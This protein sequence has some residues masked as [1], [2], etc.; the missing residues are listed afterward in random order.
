MKYARELI[1]STLVGGVFVV[2]PVYLAVLLLLKVMRSLGG[3]V[4]PV[5]ALVPDRLPAE[6]LLSLAL[7]MTFCLAVGVAIRTSTGRAVRERMEMAFLERL[8]GYGLLRRLTRRL[9]G[10]SDESTW[11]PA[12]AEIHGALVPAFII[13]ELE[14]G[15]F[16]IF[17]PSVPTPLAGAVYVISRERVHLLDIPFTGAIK[18]VSRLGSGAKNIVAAM[19]T[20]RIAPAEVDPPRSGPLSRSTI[21]S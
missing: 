9:T 16:T 14:D 18:S 2:V 12:L 5:A 10:H 1:T 7:M 11:Q 13:E 21:E 20:P 3:L 6:G 19:R 17:G 4:R 8:P 15:R